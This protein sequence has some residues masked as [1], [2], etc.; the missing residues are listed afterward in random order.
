MPM[1]VNLADSSDDASGL[2]LVASVEP[3]DVPDDPCCN[4]LVI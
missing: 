4:L 2:P 3:V 1:I